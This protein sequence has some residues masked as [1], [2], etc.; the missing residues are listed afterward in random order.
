MAALNFPDP[1]VTT[2][3][4]NPDTGIT[5]EW[6]NGVWKSVSSALTAPEL[7]VDVDGDN[8]TGN[9][10]LG[11]D[12]IVLNAT[13]GSAT[14]AGGN[15]QL[16]NGGFYTSESA[17]GHVNLNVSS[18][19]IL[20]SPDG[21]QVN[22]TTILGHDG[23]ATF[24]GYIKSANGTGSAFL[25]ASTTAGLALTN[26][27]GSTSASIFYDGG[28]EFASTVVVAP[29]NGRQI[30]LA[31]SP[32]GGII[33]LREDDGTRNITLN[34]YNG[35]AEFASAVTV[36]P[37][38]PSN[39]S[40]DGTILY[41]SGGL[42]VSKSSGALITFN[43]TGSGSTGQINADGS[44]EFAG[45]VTIQAN[46]NLGTYI[47]QGTGGAFSPGLFITKRDVDG[48]GDVA[49]F[50]GNAGRL[51][52]KGDGTLDINNQNIFLNA[53][54]SAY[55]ASNVGIGATN[56]TSLG[57]GFTEVMI[58]GNTEG[59][60]LQLQDNDGNVK[61][62]LF[63]SDNSNFATLRTI[64]NHPLTFRTNNTEAMR[65]D[66]SGRLLVG[67]YESRS[68][69]STGSPGLLQVEVNGTAAFPATFMANRSDKF[70][71]IL[72]LCKSRGTTS[73]SQTI[74][75]S[76]DILGSIIFGGTDG[77]NEIIS[78]GIKAEVDGTPGTNDIPAR[79]IFSTRGVGASSST[80]RMRISRTGRVYIGN[81]R[82]DLAAPLSVGLVGMASMSQ[83]AGANTSGL[84]RL[85]DVGT[86]NNE[87]IGLE[88]RNKNSGDVRIL[89]VDKS[90]SNTADMAFVTDAGGLSEKMRILSSGGITFNG[91]TAQANALDDYEEG[92]WS[93]VGANNF[94]GITNAEGAYVKVGKIVWISFQF[95]YD[96]LDNSTGASA[97]SGLP[98][99]P[100]NANSNT[101]IEATCVVF[102]TNKLVLSNVQDGANI[103]YF[104]T[105]RP[106]YGSTSTGSDFFRG[107]L[108]YSI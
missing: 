106:L 54:G 15:I 11:T 63:T 53:D 52:I 43:Q 98:F 20:I 60:G 70:G 28:A 61:A 92:T 103:L 40:N 101:G 95:K 62:G 100:G 55:F 18:G 6:A 22:A 36:G 3:Y 88:I 64:T 32:A 72:G 25:G 81:T 65:L 23:S 58:S 69:L 96:S 4:T 79:L 17:Y 102:G 94:N 29:D 99:N 10:T 13:D 59:A 76:D 97:V 16:F 108:V 47:G 107:S 45:G 14:F 8:L 90:V 35:S 5:Y 71:P 75:Q 93:P 66:S 78:A 56:P 37:G 83:D 38:N 42:G 80:E 89:N 82:T 105:G 74:V 68:V 39:G 48:T 24:A 41:G 85:F 34:G 49:Y 51:I 44:A 2:S 57:S 21:T 26:S 9:L 7:F 19:G 87:F 33:Y 73:G 27:G 12:K 67:T 86:A 84:L 31:N 50:E 91:D 77:S 104:E 30:E 46:S 1:N